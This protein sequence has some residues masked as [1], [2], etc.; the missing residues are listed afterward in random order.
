MA[1][2]KD[3]FQN[4]LLRSYDGKLVHFEVTSDTFRLKEIEELKQAKKRKKMLSLGY[5]L[6]V[7]RLVHLDSLG[8]N[9]HR[10]IGHK[11]CNFS[12][13]SQLSR[14]EDSRTRS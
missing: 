7:D 9:A 13:L 11:A 5:D 1:A 6:S 10:Y 8:R 4:D 14:E 12:L 3:A 2:L